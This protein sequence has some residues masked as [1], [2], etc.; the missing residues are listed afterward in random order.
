M[1]ATIS[2]GK[3]RPLIP[4]RIALSTVFWGTQGTRRAP[5]FSGTCTTR[6]MFDHSSITGAHASSDVV[7]CLAA[8]D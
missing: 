7:M 4:R 8:R 1:I 6:S 2:P 3:T 5:G